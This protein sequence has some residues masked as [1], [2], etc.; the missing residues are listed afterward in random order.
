[1][2][3]FFFNEYSVSFSNVSF[4]S[5]F[6]IDFWLDW[7]VARRYTHEIL[8]LNHNCFFQGALWFHKVHFSS[9]MLSGH[10]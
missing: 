6:L 3:F 10:I 2:V 1:M 8:L 7:T 4:S 9:L 5:Y